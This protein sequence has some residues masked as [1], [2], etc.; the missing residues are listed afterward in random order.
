MMFAKQPTSQIDAVRSNAAEYEAT[1]E[2]MRRKRLGQFF[3]GLPLGRLLAALALDPKAKQVLDP[4]AGH[5]DLLDAALE[6]AGRR[7]QALTRVDGVEI[8]PPTAEACRARLAVWRDVPGH[9]NLCIRT[10]D[11]FGWEIVRH[12]PADGYDLVVTNPPYVRYQALAAQTEGAGNRSPKDIR[13]DLLDVIQSRLG[14]DERSVW[15]ALIEGYSGLADLSVPAWILAGAFVRPGGVLALVAPATWRSRNYGD[16]IEYLL[17]RCFRLEYLVE[18]TQPGWFSDA[19][20]RTQLVVARRLSEDEARIPLAERQKDARLIITARVS[21]EASGQDNLVGTAFPTP[22]PEWAFARWMQCAA[23]GDAEQ[24]G[25]VSCEA[26]PVSELG[27]AVATSLR[28]RKWFSLVE[29]R[30]G[31]RVFF[32]GHGDNDHTV[33]VP[34]SIRAIIGREAELHAQLPE[35]AGIVI[36]QGLRTGCNGFFYVDLVREL[37]GE[38]ACVRLGELFG[39]DEIIVPSNC[40]MPVLR[41]QSKHVGRLRATALTGRTLDLSGWVLPEDVA[42]IAGSK[43]LYEREGLPVPRVMPP[44][45]A[46]Y[47][48]RASRTTYANVPGARQIPTLSAVKT[49]VRMASGR[50]PRFWYMLPTFARRHRPDAFVPRINQGVPLVEENDTPPVLIDANFST[51]WGELPSWTGPALCALFNSS[52]GRACMET[53]GTP[54]GG[55]AL[56]L[57][58]T[59]LKQLPIPMLESQ[60]LDRLAIAGR[61]LQNTAAAALDP[62]DIFVVEKLLGQK[63]NSRKI[64]GI[65]LG[66]REAAKDLCRSRQRCL[67]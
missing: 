1:L 30:A 27:Q 19:L 12:C 22:D 62:V 3:T 59:Q 20:V 43:H 15:Q 18:D 29:P 39:G 35:S 46:E 65:N 58:A 34:A 6:R 49:N 7:G 8:D 53:L 55:G 37:P 5:G 32:G 40:L 16:T 51:L 36:G 10:G 54:L 44:D 25:G 41:R 56:K 42:A 38:H 26:R 48:R 60:D 23:T 57:E 31:G 21:P 13:R 4:M 61:A 24:S 67:P 33:S 9:G 2:P 17:T 63:N 45:L 66:L 47:V 52:W 64:A 11:A 28:T 50:A 14:V